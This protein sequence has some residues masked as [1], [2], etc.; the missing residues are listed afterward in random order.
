MTFLTGALRQSRTTQGEAACVCVACVCACVCGRWLWMRVL[1]IS[2]LLSQV[3]FTWENVTQEPCA[4]LCEV[5]VY[6]SDTHTAEDKCISLY[7]QLNATNTAAV[8][9]VKHLWPPLSQKASTHTCR[10]ASDL[11]PWSTWQ[12]E[13]F[14]SLFWTWG[15]IASKISKVAKASQI[16]PVLCVRCFSAR[17]LEVYVFAYNEI[18]QATQWV[19][20]FLINSAWLFQGE[21]LHFCSQI[22]NHEAVNIIQMF[23]LNKWK[24]SQE[25]T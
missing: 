13:R 3:K 2:P 22:K 20:G 21:I 18:A 14:W 16:G 24:R 7:K 8:T 10:L 15:N 23:H 17:G 9:E 11:P 1:T 6:L 19:W 12:L 5:R 4:G 25:K